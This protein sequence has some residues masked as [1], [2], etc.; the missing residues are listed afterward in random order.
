[1]DRARRLRHRL[2]RRLLRQPPRHRRRHLLPTDEEHHQHPHS[3]E[4]LLLEH[5]TFGK[6]RLC[7]SQNFGNFQN[8]A[9]GN[10]YIKFQLEVIMK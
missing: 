7:F 8:I 1:M 6:S 2:H 9:S 3:G 5:F 4:S 10:W